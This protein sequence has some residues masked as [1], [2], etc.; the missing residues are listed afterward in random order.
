MGNLEKLEAYFEE[1]H[2]FKEGILALRH[3]ALK[4]SVTETVKWGSPVYTVDGKNVFWIARFK[5]HFG[6]GFF[7]GVFLKDPKK[8]LVNVQEGK[9][10]AM[11]HWKFNSIDDIDRPVILAYINEAIEN[12][13]R[14]MCLTPYKKKNPSLNIP[15]LL[16]EALEENPKMKK[17]F[18]S[19]SPY[20]QRDYAEYISAAKQEKTKISRLEKIM[21]LIKQGKGLNDKYNKG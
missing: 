3:L 14:G 12:E 11:R 20:K 7:N 9:T 1:A 18:T 10:Q 2:H 13:I 6:L 4:T 17:A 8:V 21:P 19:L 5:N 15:S 16:K